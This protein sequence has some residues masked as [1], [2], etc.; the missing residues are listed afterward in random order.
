MHLLLYSMHPCPPLPLMF[1]QTFNP[2]AR[3]LQHRGPRLG[4]IFQ[5]TLCVGGSVVDSA[6]QSFKSGSRPSSTMIE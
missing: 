1:R 2:D 3:L 4:D 6:C 5:L